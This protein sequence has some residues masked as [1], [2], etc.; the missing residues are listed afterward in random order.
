MRLATLTLFAGF[1]VSVLASMSHA[2]SP[3]FNGGGAFAFDPEI[4]VVNSGA[5][6][7]AQVV[8]SDDRKYVTITARPSLSRLQSLNVFPV[9]QVG[10]S[11]GGGGRG[12]NGGTGGP[13]GAQFGFVGSAGYIDDEQIAASAPTDIPRPAQSAA[14]AERG[15]HANRQ[16]PIPATPTQSSP[17]LILKVDPTASNS[18]L[19]KD[20][21]YKIE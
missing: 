3:G 8:V 20:G 15:A 18:V 1:V 17:S 5:L 10:A 12:G 14:S 13:G 2:Q 7:D 4:S 9:Q 16:A 19:R 11:G 21:M 6:V